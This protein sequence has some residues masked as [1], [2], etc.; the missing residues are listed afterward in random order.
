MKEERGR[1]LTSGSD[2]H[3]AVDDRGPGR[4]SSPLAGQIVVESGSVSECSEERI[5]RSAPPHPGP[6]H[7]QQRRRGRAV[8]LEASR[9]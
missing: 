9:R 8:T 5:R 2:D 1:T 7:D 6:R 3:Q 4:A